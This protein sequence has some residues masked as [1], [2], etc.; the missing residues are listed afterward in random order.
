MDMRKLTAILCLLAVIMASA[1]GGTLA[2]YAAE[3]RA[4]NVITSGGVDI[5]L[6]EY[7]QKED[8]TLE[9]FPEEGVSGVMPGQ[10]ISKI[11]RV[12]NQELSADAWVRVKVIK[13]FD[14]KITDQQKNDKMSFTPGP[15]WVAGEEDFYYYTQIVAPGESTTNLFENV[16]F[17]SEM[18]NEYQQTTMRLVLQAQ[19][20]QAANNPVPEGKTHADIP[21]WPG[22]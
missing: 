12:K 15:G 22:R 20:V 8:G 16:V 19:A 11:V 21:G 18:G 3:G 14:E 6:T 17:S 9:K 13:E 7:H 10:E 2:Y 1:A 4:N 5:E